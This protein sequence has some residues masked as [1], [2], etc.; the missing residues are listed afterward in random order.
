MSVHECRSP[1]VRCELRMNDGFVVAAALSGLIH[2]T[3]VLAKMSGWT[4]N[5]FW[6]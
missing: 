6:A 3:G 5:D 4:P 2:G 1:K